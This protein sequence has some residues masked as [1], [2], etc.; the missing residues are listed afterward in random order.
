MIVRVFRAIF[1]FNVMETKSGWEVV[2]R[3]I[4]LQ[5]FPLFLL[6]SWRNNSTYTGGIK[7][8]LVYVE[9]F[10]QEKKWKNPQ[11]ERP[12]ATYQPDFVS[13]TFGTLGKWRKKLG[14][15]YWLL[16]HPLIRKIVR[17]IK[18]IAN[19]PKSPCTTSP[20]LLYVCT[21]YILGF[22]V[23]NWWRAWVLLVRRA[24]VIWAHVRTHDVP[25][26]LIRFCQPAVRSMFPL[27]R[28]FSVYFVNYIW[29]WVRF[30]S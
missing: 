9:L 3:A 7:V 6:F 29:D 13:L 27:S 25:T 24:M 16:R 19:P 20:C 30:C 23:C 22:M 5:I 4:F 2:K 14:R 28:K 8:A 26:A 1:H 18:D 21:V 12:V 11:N 10:C 15:S 17:W